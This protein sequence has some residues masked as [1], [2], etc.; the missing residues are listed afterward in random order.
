VKTL[1]DF[2][3]VFREQ[4]VERKSRWGILENETPSGFT[5]K[6]HILRVVCHLAVSALVKVASLL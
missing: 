6:N 3:S 2:A 4:I 1:L 5:L